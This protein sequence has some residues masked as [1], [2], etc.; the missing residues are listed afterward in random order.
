MSC[1]QSP[2]AFHEIEILDDCV[3][4]KMGTSGGHGL[5]NLPVYPKRDRCGLAGHVNYA[6]S[7]LKA[8]ISVS[9]S[10]LVIA[11]GF[12]VVVDLERGVRSC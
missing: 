4:V 2:C 7:M 6:W 12:G 10:S 3:G 8:C 1:N 11:D 5:R 9:A